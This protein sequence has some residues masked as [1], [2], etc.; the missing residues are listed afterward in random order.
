MFDEIYD[1]ETMEKQ[2]EILSLEKH[3][4]FFTTFGLWFYLAVYHSWMVELDRLKFLKF[5]MF[6]AVLRFQTASLVET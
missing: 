5:F 1:D 6:L 2:R 3:D 4:L